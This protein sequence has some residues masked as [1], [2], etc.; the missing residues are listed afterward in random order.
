MGLPGV[1][2]LGKAAQK[3]LRGGNKVEYR[4]TCAGP[5]G[6]SETWYFGSDPVYG[7]G[8]NGPTQDQLNASINMWCGQGQPATCLWS[9]VG[10]PGHPA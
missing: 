3:Q 1:S 2:I 4:C 10:N 9:V 6:E 5:F 8:P 7:Y